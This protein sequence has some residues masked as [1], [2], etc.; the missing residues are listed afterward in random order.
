ML[1]ITILYHNILCYF[2]FSNAITIS[3]VSDFVCDNKSTRCL[4][5][6][7]TNAYTLTSYTVIATSCFRYSALVSARANEQDTLSRSSMENA[8]R[9]Y[10][11]VRLQYIKI[12]G[13]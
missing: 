6:S 10:I 3:R 12:Y 11:I 7:Y 2:F 8:I 5:L 13:S 1:P 9:I 4:S